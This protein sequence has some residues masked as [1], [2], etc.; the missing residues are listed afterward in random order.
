M[1]VTI[2]IDMTPDE[3][4]RFLGLPD[5]GNM[6]KFQEQLMTNAQQFLRESGQ[7]QMADIVTSAMQP[8]VAYQNWLQSMMNRP[9]SG[10]STGDKSDS[11]T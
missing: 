10:D 4:R 11:T 8:M 9:A 7:N 3:A 2:D 6:E 5:I 1:K